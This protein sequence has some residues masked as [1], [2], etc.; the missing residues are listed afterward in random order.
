MACG[1]ILIPETSCRV[2]FEPPGIER[3]LHRQVFRWAAERGNV[4][5]GAKCHRN[6]I[7]DRVLAAGIEIDAV[8]AAAIFAMAKSQMANDDIIG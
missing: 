3:P 6:V 1:V 8:T 5:I 2:G 4:F 7:K